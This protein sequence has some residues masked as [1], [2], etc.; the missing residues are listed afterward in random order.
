M[1]ERAGRAISFKFMSVVL[2]NTEMTELLNCCKRRDT[3]QNPPLKIMNIAICPLNKGSSN[4][5][6]LWISRK[7]MSVGLVNVQHLHTKNC[8]SKQP[9]YWQLGNTGR[10]RQSMAS[11][12]II[13]IIIFFF[14]PLNSMG[15]VDQISLIHF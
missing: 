11:Y 8:W 5:N 10:V 13:I 6:S 15:S 7:H 2:G 9:S 14:L 3:V 1:H 12:F 4:A